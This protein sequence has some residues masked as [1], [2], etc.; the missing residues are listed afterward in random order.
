[1]SNLIGDSPASKELSVIKDPFVKNGLKRIHINYWGDYSTPH[2]DARVEF[3]NGMTSG[4][5]K[6]PNCATFDE[7]MMHVKQILDSIKNR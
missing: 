4:E 3:K 2:W 5:Q 7:V 6:T 1:M